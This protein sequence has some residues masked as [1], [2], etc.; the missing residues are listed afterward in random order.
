MPAIHVHDT[1]LVYRNPSPNIWSRQAYFP[2]IL[3]TTEGALLA[4]FDLGSAM[5]AFDVRSCVCRSEDEGHTWTA[6]APLPLPFDSDRPFTTTCRTARISDDAIVSLATRFDRSRQEH[7]LANPQTDG[8]VETEFYLLRSNDNA[9]TWSSPERIKL[10]VPWDRFESCSPVI[11]VNDTHWILPTSVWRD[12]DGNCPLGLK[13]V[14]FISDD[15]GVTWGDCVDVMDGVEQGIAY[16]EQ[17]QVVLSDGRLLA[18]C[19]AYDLNEGKSLMNRYAIS[20]SQGASFTFPADTPLHGE[21]CTPLALDGNCILCA[22]RRTDERGL[23]AHLARI[24]NDSWMPLADAPLWGT[25]RVSYTKRASGAFDQFSTLQFGY[26]QMVR[27]AGGDIFLVFWCVENCVA[28]IRWVRL[29]VE[30]S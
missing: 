9:R 28:N 15:G 30:V 21:T 3:T 13:A 5:E 24:E 4:T 29:S 23:W 25:E 19:W 1:G 8:F 2:S 11:A 26:P 6:P 16:W 17:K 12:W 10:P 27:L 18:V 22:Y 7:G 14:A 20:T